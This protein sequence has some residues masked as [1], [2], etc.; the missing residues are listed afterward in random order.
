M[1]YRSFCLL[2]LAG[3]SL[4]FSSKA[5]PAYD[6]TDKEPAQFNGVEY[7]Y[8]IRNETRKDMGS[9]G[10]FQ[11]YELTV[12]VTNKSGCT[13]LF[14]PRPTTFGLQNQDLLANFD[15]VNATGARLT[16]KTATVRA[17]PF[18]V[19]YSTS[20]KNAEGKEVINTVQVQAGHILDNGET[21]A[22]HIIVIVPEGELPRMR[23]RI[24]TSE[25]TV[26]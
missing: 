15:C 9:K 26:R 22:N 10:T 25:T 2:L 18:L 6:I 13:K 8:S 21:V 14:F 11:R 24:Q 1:H 7:G 12:Y 19:P 16:S 5:Q 23:V 3:L 4:S 20:S 17:R